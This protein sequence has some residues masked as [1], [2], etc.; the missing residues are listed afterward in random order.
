MRVEVGSEA[1]AEV[2]WA[3][4][5]NDDEPPEFRVIGRKVVGKRNV[6]GGTSLPE[7]GWEDWTRYRDDAKAALWD[8]MLGEQAPARFGI[9]EDARLRKA[10]AFDCDAYSGSRFYLTVSNKDVKDPLAQPDVLNALRQD[11]GL[12]VLF[13]AD[14]QQ[15]RFFSITD[16][17]LQ[18]LIK[19][20]L[21]ILRD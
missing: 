8:A 9:D 7:E 18:D 4:W 6:L 10:F 15:D 2:L 21:T 16:M 13:V 14:S 5:R 11:L 20:C 3:R 12:P 19:Q 1:G 17:R